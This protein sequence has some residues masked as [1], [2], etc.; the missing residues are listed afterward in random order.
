[1]LKA[2]DKVADKHS[3]EN[4]FFKKVYERRR[5]MPSGLFPING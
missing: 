2:W 5:L 1:V 3:K 4:A